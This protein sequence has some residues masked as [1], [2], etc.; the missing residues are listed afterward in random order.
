MSR[1]LPEQVL[2]YLGTLQD[3]MIQDPQGRTLAALSQALGV[4]D[5]SLTE[6]AVKLLVRDNLV[7]RPQGGKR[8]ELTDEGWSYIEAMPGERRAHKGGRVVEGNGFRL[9]PI[10][11]ETIQR[12][13]RGSI[14][15]RIVESFMETDELAVEVTGFGEKK[16]SLVAS[17]AKYIRDNK[18]ACSVS[19]RGGRV[20][21]LRNEKLKAVSA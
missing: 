2:D 10:D 7:K 5:V 8:I 6:G 4:R 17:I 16:N 13:G 20:V 12:S 14:G 18:I 11:P 9:E 19:G 15:A 3:G 1:T 21:L